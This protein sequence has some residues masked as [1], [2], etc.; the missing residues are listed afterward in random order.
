MELQKSEHQPQRMMQQC[1]SEVQKFQQAISAKKINEVPEEF[2][3]QALRYAMMKIGLRGANFPEGIEKSLLLQ[4]IYENFGELTPDEIKIAFDW[5]IDDR[6][7]LG[8]GGFNCYENFSCAYVTKILKAYLKRRNSVFGVQ[9]IEEKPR[10][11]IEA[12][13]SEEF[14]NSEFAQRLKKLGLKIPE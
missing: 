11:Q 6:L 4:H 2:L 5:A 14:L 3:R 9:K 8:E 7:E 10:L 1:G 13:I 12:P